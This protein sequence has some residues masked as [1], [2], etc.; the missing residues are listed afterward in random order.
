MPRQCQK[1]GEN[2]VTCGFT[3]TLMKNFL[4]HTGNSKFRAIIAAGGGWETLHFDRGQSHV[5]FVLDLTHFGQNP[6]PWITF[7]SDVETPGQSVR[8]IG[9]LTRIVFPTLPSYDWASLERLYQPDSKGRLSEKLAFMYLRWLGEVARMDPAVVIA[10]ARLAADHPLGKLFGDIAGYVTTQSAIRFPLPRLEISEPHAHRIGSIPR[11]MESEGHPLEPERVDEF[12][13]AGV[14]RNAMSY[15]DRPSQK[16]LARRVAQAFNDGDLL[17]AE[18]GTGTGKSLAYLV[19][20][21]MWSVQNGFPVVVS[22]HT[23]NLQDQLFFKDIRS[24]TPLM[25]F[26]ALLV[27][28]RQNYLCRKKIREL[29]EESTSLVKPGERLAAL[30]L[31]FWAARTQS[32]DISECTAFDS[33]RYPGLWQKLAS[34]PVHCQIKKCLPTCPVRQIRD[35]VRNAHVI[36]VNHALLFS[37]LIAQNAILGDYAHVVFDEAHHLEKVAQDYLGVEFSAR[38]VRRLVQRLYDRDQQATGLVVKIRKL[39]QDADWTGSESAFAMSLIGAVAEQSERCLKS[40]QAYLAGVEKSLSTGGATGNGQLKIRYNSNDSPLRSSSETKVEFL[41]ALADWRASVVNLLG[42]MRSWPA[43][44]EAEEVRDQLERVLDEIK[45]LSETVTFL[46]RAD[47]A[48]YVYWSEWIPSRKGDLRFYAVPL[49]VGDLLHQLL[50]SRLRTAVFSSATL[51]VQ[52]QFDHTRRR[53]GLNHEEFRLDEISLASPFDYASQCRVFVVDGMPDPQ[54]PDF[55]V[56]AAE[57][58]DELVC[59]L[60]KNTLVLFTSYLMMNQCHRLLKDRWKENGM[61]LILQGLDGSRSQLAEQMKTRE[62]MVLFGTDS[63]WE[64]VDLP[65]EA[66]EV[67]I[68]TKLPFEVPTE[69]LVAA[70]LEL[71]EHG[72]GRPFF[73]YSLP[74]AVLKFRQ[75]FGRLIR[76]SSD[77]GSVVILDSRVIRKS[78]GKYFLD[79]IDA[80]ATVVMRTSEAVRRLTDFF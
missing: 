71:I 23:K 40:T 43:R 50:F 67:L 72:G 27:K 64:G 69:P 75:G 39:V 66:L 31:V 41:T 19:P 15:E 73:D 46:E 53:L 55:T 47:A 70:K 22:T 29:Y 76:Q 36:V 20:A 49:N 3:E 65:G 26:R 58:I 34:D 44:L 57:A 63:F 59:G 24:L 11:A 74:E 17:L 28:G 52:G 8:E 6:V 68:I 38:S 2:F 18:A 79:S 56:A 80:K 51:S 9:W 45:T 35:E 14:L 10:A 60:R 62:A 16:V 77:R 21:V 25:D 54:H 5:D 4:H 61:T 7:G 37:D 33:D 48:H 13:S 30:P 1:S 32:G 78:Y 42:S 12:F